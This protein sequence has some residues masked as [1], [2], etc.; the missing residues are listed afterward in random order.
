M[1]SKRESKKLG[2]VVWEQKLTSTCLRQCGTASYLHPWPSTLEPTFIPLWGH[3]LGRAVLCLC[4]FTFLNCS[5][6]ESQ[7]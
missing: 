2:S 7:P 4:L 6:V 3:R 1:E 5:F